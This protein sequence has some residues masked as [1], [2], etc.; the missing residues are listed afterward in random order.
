MTWSLRLNQ[1]KNQNQNRFQANQS[2][3]RRCG[4]AHTCKTSDGVTPCV[5]DK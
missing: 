4:I 3:T 1:N 2:T 5:M